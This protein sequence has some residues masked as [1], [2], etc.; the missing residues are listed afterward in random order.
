MLESLISPVENSSYI[1]PI[2]KPKRALKLIARNNMK[3]KAEQSQTCK[4]S[5][6][7]ILFEGDNKRTG[8]KSF[9][10]P[11]ACNKK[12]KIVR[13]G[14]SNVSQLILNQQKQILQVKSRDRPS[15]VVQLQP[16]GPVLQIKKF[17]FNRQHGLLSLNYNSVKHAQQKHTEVSNII[18]FSNQSLENY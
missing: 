17:K 3:G 16:D 10:L 6:D 7:S 8:L 5:L 12:L 18:E 9:V 2:V 4:N 13:G 11:S 15:S 1:Q 14:K